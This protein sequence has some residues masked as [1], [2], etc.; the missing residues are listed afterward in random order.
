M[1]Y[2]SGSIVFF[3]SVLITL[4]SFFLLTLKIALI[5]FIIYFFLAAGG[6]LPPLEIIPFVPYI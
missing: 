1:R 5:G 4:L 6:V 3:F 2:I